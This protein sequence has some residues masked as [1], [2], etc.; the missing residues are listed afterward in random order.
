MP[1]VLEELTAL[2]RQG[3]IQWT[4]HVQQRIAQRGIKRQE[5]KEAII[6]GEIIEEY[7]TDYPFPSCLILGKNRLH[8]VCGIGENLL[9]IITAYRPTNDKWEPDLKTRKERQS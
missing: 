8:V 2:C 7:P 5:V 3:K 1:I 6:T 9:W 4:S